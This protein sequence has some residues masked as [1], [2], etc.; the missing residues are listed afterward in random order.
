MTAALPRSVSS[1]IVSA[2]RRQAWLNWI[3][4]SRLR[5]VGRAW[6]AAVLG[7]FA[8]IGG[9]ALLGL[10]ASRTVDNPV[11]AQSPAAAESIVLMGLHTRNTD[12]LFLDGGNYRATW[13]AWGDSPSDPPCTHSIQLMLADAAGASTSVMDLARS[14][15]VPGTGMSAQIDLTDLATGDYYFQVRSAC[16]WQIELKPV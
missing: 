11:A 12:P 10:S 9:I 15:Q 16:A 5:S 3:V 4:L 14:V 6:L 7:A 1:P 8:V 13:S 2:H